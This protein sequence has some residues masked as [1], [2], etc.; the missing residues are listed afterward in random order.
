MGNDGADWNGRLEKFKIA[1]QAHLSY[2][3]QASEGQAVD[4]HLLG[5]SLL[6]AGYSLIIPHVWL[7]T[8]D[9]SYP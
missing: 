6:L 9:T 5:E 1:V 7:M 3:Q 2:S 8:V 4:R